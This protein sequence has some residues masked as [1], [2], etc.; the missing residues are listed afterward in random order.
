[1]TSISTGGQSQHRDCLHV[2]ITLVFHPGETAKNF[3]VK[4]GV[5]GRPLTAFRFNTY[6]GKRVRPTTYDVPPEGRA[7]LYASEWADLFY[8]V[9]YDEYFKKY[10]C[11][12]EQP[13]CEHIQ[14]FRKLR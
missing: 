11:T 10:S 6:A 9:E 13:Y 12:C 7:H 3:E 8:V 4:G 14:H 1:M 5:Y 2:L